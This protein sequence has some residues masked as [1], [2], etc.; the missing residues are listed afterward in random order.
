MCCVSPLCNSEEEECWSLSIKKPCLQG[1]SFHVGTFEKSL[2]VYC[3]TTTCTTG[4]S[5]QVRRMIVLQHLVHACTSSQLNH[6]GLSFDR[7][8]SRRSVVYGTTYHNTVHVYGVVVGFLRLRLAL[9]MACTVHAKPAQRQGSCVS[10][11]LASMFDCHRLCLSSHSHVYFCF[12]S[13]L[14]FSCSSFIS[15]C[16]FD[17]H[18]PTSVSCP[19]SHSHCPLHLMCSEFSQMISVLG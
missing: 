10:H 16:H 5:R 11:I 9:S 14:P 17:S 7:C 15:C 4:L 8:S 19:H 3:S 2:L 13:Q 18:M 12:N 6:N 1:T